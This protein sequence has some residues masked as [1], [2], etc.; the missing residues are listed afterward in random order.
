M[1]SAPTSGWTVDP[2]LVRAEQATATLT[3]DEHV[4]MVCGDLLQVATRS[5]SAFKR[6]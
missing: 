5:L 4:A 1:R 3:D 6:L 2:Y